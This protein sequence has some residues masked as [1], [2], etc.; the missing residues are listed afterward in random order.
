MDEAGQKKMEGQL[1]LWG[2]RIDK[3]AA[4]TQ[5]PGVQAGFEAHM[6]IDELK[7]LHAIAQSKYDEFGAA[8]Y[9]ERA[10]LETEMKSAWNELGAAFGI[11]KP[12][13]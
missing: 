4:R 7:A 13:P 6:H 11:P 1:R 8:G 12:T 5:T 3:I 10:R 9:P 2:L